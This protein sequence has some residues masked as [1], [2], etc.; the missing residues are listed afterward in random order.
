MTFAADQEDKNQDQYVI[1]SEQKKNQ[2]LI[3]DLWFCCEK[4]CQ[5]SQAEGESNAGGIASQGAS[6]KNGCDSVFFEAKKEE[7]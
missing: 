2:T 3:N 4:N 1:S 6:Q 7:T 5:P